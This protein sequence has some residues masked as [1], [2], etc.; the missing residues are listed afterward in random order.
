MTRDYLGS[1]IVSVKPLSRKTTQITCQSRKHADRET[2]QAKRYPHRIAYRVNVYGKR[3]TGVVTA[4]NFDDRPKQGKVLR[5]TVRGNDGI[6]R[7]FYVSRGLFRDIALLARR[8]KRG[9][10]EFNLED[11]QRVGRYLLD[12]T[13]V[14]EAATVTEV[15]ES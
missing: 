9:P 2:A 1:I 12:K 15:K 10:D 8:D 5:A 14:I 13:V 6:S 7:G 3:E 4:Y 11:G